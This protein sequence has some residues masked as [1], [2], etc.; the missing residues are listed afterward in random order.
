MEQLL[1]ELLSQLE[2]IGEI[3]G[4]LYDSEVREK[5]GEAVMEGYVRNSSGYRPPDHFGMYSVEADAAVREA[6][7]AYIVTANSLADRIG[8]TS[9]KVRLA[10]F[11]NPAVR[12]SSSVQ[13][14]YD[15][16]FGH[17]PPEWYDEG[18][19]VLWDRVR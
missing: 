8:L 11:Q 18:G 1:L 15:D 19:N 12:T 6:L 5:M 2:A 9:F 7:L 10:A 16:M 3:H 4:E 17:T 14:Y 13:C